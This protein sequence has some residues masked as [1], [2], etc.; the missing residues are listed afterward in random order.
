ML[1][2]DFLE[3]GNWLRLHVAEMLVM[4]KS[5]TFWKQGW[6]LRFQR[7]AERYTKES[8]RLF[9]RVLPLVLYHPNTGELHKYWVKE[10][11]GRF[12]LEAFE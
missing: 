4:G 3:A 8:L 7:L 11:D 12:R 1:Y 9:D 6:E 10:E 2:E 5:E